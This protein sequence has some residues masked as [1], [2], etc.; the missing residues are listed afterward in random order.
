MHRSRQ[1][2]RFVGQLVAM[3]WLA[4]AALPSAQR[5]LRPLP[6]ALAAASPELVDRLRADSFT[7]FR[8]INRTWTARV[9]E[10]LA[11]LTDAP[12]VRLHGDAH[13]EQFAVTKDAW[14]RAAT[15]EGNLHYR[16]RAARGLAGAGG[17]IAL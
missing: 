14:G 7:Y 13:V 5:S 11:D 2:C 4:L 15:A 6:E 1:G 9:C 10:A 12:T 17:T 8:F 3:L 16:R